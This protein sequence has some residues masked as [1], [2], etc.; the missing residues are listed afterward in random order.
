MVVPAEVHRIEVSAPREDQRVQALE[1]LR[2]T[3]LS[4]REQ[5][6][7]TASRADRVH[8]GARKMEARAL[9]DLPVVCGDTDE[10]PS[11]H[12]PPSNPLEVALTLEVRHRRLEA[13]LLAPG[14]V[15][16][17]VD[18]VVAEAAAGELAALELRDRLRE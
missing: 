9:V 2:R 6:R 3:L 13:S 7:E 14:E 11:R 10:R 8:I 12:F 15:K 17:V 1:Q 4:R 18:H 16:Q 5:Y